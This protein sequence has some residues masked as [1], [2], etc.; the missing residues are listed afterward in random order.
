MYGVES[1]LH[2]PDNTY[3]LYKLNNNLSIMPDVDVA[4]INAE[5]LNQLLL[6]NSIFEIYNQTG[7]YKQKNK[8][9]RRNK[10]KK[11]KQT[12]RRKNI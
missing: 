2:F 11:R 8:K 12:R 10:N 6:P 1:V 7:G 5:Y 9:S 4:N 3:R